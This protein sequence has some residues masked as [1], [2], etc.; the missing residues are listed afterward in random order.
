MKLLRWRKCIRRIFNL[1]STWSFH[2]NVCCT[3]RGTSPNYETGVIRLVK[4]FFHFAVWL[5]TADVALVSDAGC[6]W[7]LALK[8]WML[9][10]VQSWDDGCLLRCLVVVT[11]DLAL[12]WWLSSRWNL[13]GFLILFIF[14]LVKVHG[15]SVCEPSWDMF[16]ALFACECWCPQLQDH[17]P[18][19]VLN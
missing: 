7:L 10:Q 8:L 2:V 4:F 11:A 13:F 14:F 12:R 6:V 9:I 18:W 5:I 16:T 15:L 19:E 17:H 3:T 1:Y